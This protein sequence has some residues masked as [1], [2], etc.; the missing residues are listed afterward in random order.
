MVGDVMIIGPVPGCPLLV[1]CTAIVA[2]AVG[3]VV[4]VGLTRGGTCVAELALVALLVELVEP[5]AASASISSIPGTILEKC[6]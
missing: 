4:V 2:V 3:L 5:H 1:V 6:R